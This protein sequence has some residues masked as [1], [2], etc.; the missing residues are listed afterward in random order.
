MET[1]ESLLLTKLFVPQMRPNRVARPGLVARLNQALSGKLTLVSAPAGFGKT[2]LIADWLQQVDRP[3]TW[4]SLGEGDNDPNRFLIYLIAALQRI[5]NTWGQTVQ[6]LLRAPQP[7]ALTA[8]VVT[9]I[10]D[11]A[12][13]DSPLVLVLDDYH[14]I[15]APSIHEALGFLLENLPPQM[16]LVILSRADPPLPLPRLRA[17]GEVIEIRADDLRFTTEEVVAFLNEVMNLGLTQKQIAILESRTEGW[18]AGLQLA[19]LS[20]QGLRPDEVADL[21]E[22]F[23]GSHR[24]VMDYLVE[25]VFDRQPRH[26]QQFLLRTSILDRLSGP[27][28]DAIL[29]EGRT[30][31]DEGRETK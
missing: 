3:F 10:N 29:D 21:I 26:V 11:I 6:E 18:V 14:F 27:L 16:H 5:D 28:C 12:A 30:T 13:G 24:Y 17:R 19:S 22:A 23:A 2:T 9:L 15:S 25:E 8:M 20:L 7:P 31:T 4:F 1:G